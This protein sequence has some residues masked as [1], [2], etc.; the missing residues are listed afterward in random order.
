VGIERG[1]D[2]DIQGFGVMVHGDGFN[3][4]RLSCVPI[5]AELVIGWRDSQ[6]FGR[7]SLVDIEGSALWSINDGD[8]PSIWV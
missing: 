3:G 4:G 6:V 2:S 7:G 1:G 8:D 5:I